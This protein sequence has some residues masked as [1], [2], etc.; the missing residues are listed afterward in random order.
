MKE[1]TTRKW[2]V[3]T[4]IIAICLVLAI[5]LCALLW[6]G[7]IPGAANNEGPKNNSE[8]QQEE[9]VPGSLSRDGMTLEQVVVL[10]RHNIRSPLSSGDSVLASITDHSWFEWSSNPS[11]LSLRGVASETIMGQFFKKWLEEEGLFPENYRPEANEVRIYANSKQR[12]IATANAFS[13]GLLPSAKIETET[14]MEFDEMDPVFTPQFTFMNDAYA[15]AAEAEVLD[16]YGEKMEALSDNYELLEKVIDMKDTEAYKNG[17]IKDFDPSNAEWKYEINKEP[18]V[19]GSLKTACSVSDALVLQYYEEKDA[20]KAAFGHELS[21]DEWLQISEIKDVYGEVL[22][23]TPLIAPVVAHPLL[24]EIEKEMETEGRVF[25]FLCGHDSNLFSVLAALEAEDTPLPNTLERTA[26]IGCKLVIGKWKDASGAEKISVDLVY[27]TTEQLRDMS[28]LDLNN[29]PAIVPVVLQGL[30][31][32][33]NGLYDAEEFMTRL[34]EAIAQYE[35]IYDFY[36]AEE[37][38]A[39]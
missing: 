15:E 11:E 39:A 6:T 7:V 25:T 18:Q 17:E 9:S 36:E 28:L 19:S 32:D 3:L 10:S 30:Q 2:K 34:G 33:A 37:K 5:V 26:P 38:V 13:A 21:F 14:H 29:H 1:H 8:A 22:F 24:M 35:E 27:Q 31:A 12:T 16:L 20:T 4:A 23:T